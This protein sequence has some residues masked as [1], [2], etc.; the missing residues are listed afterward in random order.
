MR[1]TAISDIHGSLIPIPKTDL[2]IIAGDWSPLEIQQNDWAM[3]QWLATQ[4]IPWMKKI[5]CSRAIFQVI[6]E[7]RT[8]WPL[9]GG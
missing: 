6:T 2:L 1:I 7:I 5:E 9:S 8:P 3:R 4:F